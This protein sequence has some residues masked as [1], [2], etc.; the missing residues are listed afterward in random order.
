MAPPISL[1]SLLLLR[2]PASPSLLGRCLPGFVPLSPPLTPS[3]FAS[4]PGWGSVCLTVPSAEP[5]GPQFHAQ[6]PGRAHTGVLWQPST[7]LSP[8]APRPCRPP[9]L[10]GPPSVTRLSCVLVSTGSTP[11]PVS[12]GLTLSLWSCSGSVASLCPK[13][14]FRSTAPLLEL[15]GT[16]AQGGPARPPPR[17]LRLPH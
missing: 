10:C 7:N 4:A 8:R 15:K 13:S 14:T 6:G 1:L 5:R 2:V 3:T 16:P 9:A 12:R 17:M 11:V